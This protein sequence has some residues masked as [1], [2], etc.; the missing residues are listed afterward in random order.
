MGGV[1]SILPS[2]N[3]LSND[4]K[5]LRFTDSP[6]HFAIGSNAPT[7]NPRRKNSI[8][9]N[10]DPYTTE[11]LRLERLPPAYGAVQPGIT[12][13]PPPQYSLS[14]GEYFRP[15]EPGFLASSDYQ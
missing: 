1:P 15:I 5:P 8:T 6:Q 4:N 11:L 10:D 13:Y 7:P 2:S 9:N 12:D 14:G 3:V